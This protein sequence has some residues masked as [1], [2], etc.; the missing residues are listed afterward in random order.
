[1]ERAPAWT[2]RNVLLG[3]AAT[4]AGAFAVRPFILASLGAGRDSVTLA[5]LPDTQYYSESFPEIFRAQTLYIRER[6]R[7]DNIRLVVHEGDV[8]NQ[9]KKREQWI[10]ADASLKILEDGGVPYTVAPGNHD[11]APGDGVAGSPSA[12]RDMVEWESTFPL[13]RFRA[14]PT[15]GGSFDETSSN[16]WHLVDAGFA[17]FLVIS[18]AFGPTDD[19]LAWA[20]EVVRQHPDC[21]VQINTHSYM[22]SDNTRLGPE[23]NGDPA[24]YPELGGGNDG[25]QI[26]DKLIKLHPNIYKVT[27]GHVTTGPRAREEGCHGYRTDA[28]VHGNLV[29][30]VLANFQTME[31]GGEGWML[32][33]KIR[34]VGT[35]RLAVSVR[36]YSP[37]LDRY[38]R[39]ADANFD[40]EI[41]LAPPC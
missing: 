14:M 13:Q 3:A 10:E 7:A 11:M 35:D 17:K 2:R 31:H 20:N 40:F 8:V 25:E 34:R 6:A 30:Q 1:M 37:W 41:P 38:N 28:G 22:Y 39:S 18:M 5:I 15:F 29:H 12:R 16:T 21:H 33:E 27:S 9:P 4:A 23:D 24:E 36:T 19:V 26:W 32:T